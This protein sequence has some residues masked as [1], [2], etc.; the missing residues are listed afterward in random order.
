MFVYAAIYHGL[1][2]CKVIAV[3]NV[4]HAE[5]QAG[6]QPGETVQFPPS[7]KFRKDFESV[8]Y[9]FN[10]FGV[11]HYNKLQSFCLPPDNFSCLRPWHRSLAVMT[12]KLLCWRR[13]THEKRSLLEKA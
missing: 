5:R 12:R 1:S 4:C 6:P 8:N 2:R 13:A 10:F 11:K 3:K 9:F 7:R